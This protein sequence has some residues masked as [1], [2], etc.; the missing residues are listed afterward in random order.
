MR[1]LNLSLPLSL[2]LPLQY[3]ALVLTTALLVGSPAQAATIGISVVSDNSVC[4]TNGAGSP[5]QQDS[6]VFGS[7]VGMAWDVQGGTSPV[8]TDVGS[9]STNLSIDAVAAVDGGGDTTAQARLNFDLLLDIQVDSPNSTWTVDLD[10]GALGLF[11]LRGDG[12]GSQVGDQSDGSASISQITTIVG[13]SFYN[14]TPSPNSFSQDVDG[15]SEVSQVFSGARIDGGILSGTGDQ[16]VAV[17]IDFDLTA[18]SND[19]CSGFICSSASGGEE[20]G[21]LFGSEGVIDQAVDDY[22]T[23]SRSLGPDGYE[24]TWTLNV[25]FVPEPGTGL[26]VAMG[27]AGIAIRRRRG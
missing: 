12:F 10:Q 20:A 4:T 26:L 19:G 24:S 17:N 22:S 9:T 8:L 2:P 15:S 11:G 16:T 7:D 3:S 21:A 14:F 5:C 23:W 25:T 18:F 6:T 1:L 27:L 13:T